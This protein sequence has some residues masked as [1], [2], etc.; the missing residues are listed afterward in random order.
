MKDMELGIFRGQQQW[1]QAV[2]PSRGS[3]GDSDEAAASLV[4]VSAPLLSGTRT[5]ISTD[6]C[7]FPVGQKG[8]SRNMDCQALVPAF[9]DKHLLQF[10]SWT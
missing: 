1:G 2:R 9:V 10:F 4:I 6:I 3:V 8:C 5:Y 7:F